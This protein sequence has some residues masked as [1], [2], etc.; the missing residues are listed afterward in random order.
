M[1]LLRKPCN[2]KS[3]LNIILLKNL[4]DINIQCAKILEWHSL[5]LLFRGELRFD[6]KE[7]LRT[8]KFNK[9]VT[10]PMGNR[11]RRN[12]FGILIKPFQ[13]I[14]FYS[15][16]YLFYASTFFYSAIL[17]VHAVDWWKNICNLNNLNTYQKKQV[18]NRRFNHKVCT[19]I[20]SHQP[21]LKMS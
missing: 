20:S 9:P 12:T 13:I 11:C 4:A 21:F 5:L 2:K 17:C 8:E 16:L 19:Q 1:A 15:D 14:F 3:S 6:R 18:R 7:N 10:S